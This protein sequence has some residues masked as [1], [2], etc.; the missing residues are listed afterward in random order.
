VSTVHEDNF[1][2]NVNTAQCRPERKWCA[3]VCVCV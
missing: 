2:H 1:R 3:R